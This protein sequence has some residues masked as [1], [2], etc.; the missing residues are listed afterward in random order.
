M[1]LGSLRV[2]GRYLQD[3]LEVPGVDGEGVVGGAIAGD[4]RQRLPL[5]HRHP[6]H[7]AVPR[8]VLDLNPRL[9]LL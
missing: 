8:R 2:T 4:A 1:A 9:P 5:P 3:G 7:V 6:L